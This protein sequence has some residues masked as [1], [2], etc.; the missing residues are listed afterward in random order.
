MITPVSP[1]VLCVP[2][3]WSHYSNFRL[4]VRASKFLAPAPTSRSVWLRF[5]L[6]NNLVQK[7]RKKHCIIC[8]TRLSHKLSLWI[9]NPNFRLRFHHLKVFGSDSRHSK[10]LQLQLHSP[11]AIIHIRPSCWTIYRL[12]EIIH[13]RELS[14]GLEFKSNVLYK[15]IAS[16]NI[17]S[18]MNYV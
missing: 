8:I 18:D 5:R 16:K 2:R 10:L 3:L 1:Q 14:I 6:Q 12:F 15:S 7:I 13:E 17:Q 11:A 4:R 9:R